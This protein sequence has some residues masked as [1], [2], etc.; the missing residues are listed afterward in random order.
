MTDPPLTR[1]VVTYLAML[2]GLLAMRSVAA[3]SPGLEAE[4]AEVHEMVWDELTVDER[5]VLDGS[6]GAIEKLKR[7]WEEGPFTGDLDA[8]LAGLADEDLRELHAES[9]AQVRALME[10]GSRLRAQIATLEHEVG[11]WKGEAAET[12]AAYDLLRQKGVR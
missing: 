6:G 5:D 8:F 3:V 12:K 11:L 1:R 10:E 2:E 7:R 4:I 9:E